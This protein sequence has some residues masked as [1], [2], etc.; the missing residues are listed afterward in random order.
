M[1]NIGKL[2]KRRRIRDG[3]LQ[4]EVAEYAGVSERALST[5]ENG[6]DTSGRTLIAV[7][8]ALGLLEEI[9][10]VIKGPDISPL[11]E[12]KKIGRTPKERQRVRKL[13]VAPAGTRFKWGDEL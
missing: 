6:G 3:R 8:G 9:A 7:L 12:A 13:K 10:K 4:S 2:I 11:E 5:L 1:V